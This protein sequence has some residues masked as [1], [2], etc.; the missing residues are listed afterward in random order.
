MNKN[1]LY[2]E[3]DKLISLTWM[4]EKQ[5]VKYGEMLYALLGYNDLDIAKWESEHGKPILDTRSNDYFSIQKL[6]KAVGAKISQVSKEI[7]VSS[8]LFQDR[9]GGA[10]DSLKQIMG[11]EWILLLKSGTEANLIATEMLSHKNIPVY[12]DKHSH[13][14]TR[15]GFNMARGRMLI[16]KHLKAD[17]EKALTALEKSNTPGDGIYGIIQ[18]PLLRILESLGF[19]SFNHNDYDHLD[20]QIKK[21][22]PGIVYTEGLFSVYGDLL[23][24]EIAEIS[25]KHDC[26]LVLDESHSLFGTATSNLTINRNLPAKADI[27]TAS[28]SKAGCSLLGVVGLQPE[29]F[30]K[31]YVYLEK[32]LKRTLTDAERERARLSLINL[33]RRSLFIVFSNAASDIEESGLQARINF[34]LQSPE[35]RAI[36]LDKTKY[37]REKIRNAGIKLLSESPMMF[38]EVGSEPDSVEF[39]NYLIEQHGIIGSLYIPPATPINGAGVRLCVNYDICSDNEQVERFIYGIIDAHKKIKFDNKCRKNN[40]LYL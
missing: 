28:L 16:D 38:F 7:H 33:F 12:F 4:Q 8:A 32:K 2:D 40:E 17:I 14:S 15:G 23:K 29:F 26:A 13:A 11:S 39:R 3:I 21:H 36:L 30:E 27:L 6:P 19:Y 24:P 5:Y 10:K 18:K 20:E 34:L 37:I 25:K 31:R 35:R 9:Q 1:L 22:G